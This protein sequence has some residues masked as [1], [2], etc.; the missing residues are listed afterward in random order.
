MAGRPRRRGSIPCGC[1][2]LISSPKP[3]GRGVKPI[4]RLQYCWGSEQVELRV[5]LHFPPCQLSVQ[6]DN[7]NLHMWMC[8]SVVLSERGRHWMKLLQDTCQCWVLVK[9][10]MNLQFAP[11]W[12]GVYW[13]AV[14]L[15]ASKEI[16]CSMRLDFKGILWAS[17]ASVVSQRELIM[18]KM[19]H[20]N[21][22]LD[23]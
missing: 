15:S 20:G 12:G 14:E 18:P 7:L 5:Q 13:L 23:L 21:G 10:V 8:L 1:R 6:R 3:S 2:W 4:T 9:T 17:C 11:G 16:L 19:S 22:Q